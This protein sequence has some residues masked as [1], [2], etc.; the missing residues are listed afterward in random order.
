MEETYNWSLILK[1][2]VPVSLAEAYIFYSNVGNVWKWTSLI[3]GLLLATGIVY[4]KDK[5][6]SS[7]FTAAAIIFLAV[8]TVKLLKEFGML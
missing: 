3:A 8:L 2:A 4:Q 7:I 6:R 1:A 5:K